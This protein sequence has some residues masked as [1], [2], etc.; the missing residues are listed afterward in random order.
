MKVN[1]NSNILVNING[2][3]LP[4]LDNGGNITIH[5]LISNI[6]LPNM[7]IKNREEK[8]IRD[9]LVIKF[10]SENRI[11]DFS[12]HEASYLIDNI[13][14]IEINFPRIGD[15]KSFLIDVFDGNINTIKEEIEDENIN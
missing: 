2:K 5:H 12:S 1:L 4:I 10:N 11:Q 15:I 9:S 13:F 8:N 14:N 3:S 7:D 6:I